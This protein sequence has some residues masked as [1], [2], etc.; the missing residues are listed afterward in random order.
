MRIILL[1]DVPGQGKCG[2]VLNVKEGYARNYLFPRNLAV[3]ASKGKI[4]ELD[5]RRQA[6][7]I[8]GR[9]KEYEARELAAAIKDVTVVVKAKTGEGGKLFGSVNN[10]DIADALVSQH[11]IRLDKKKIAVQEPIKRLGLYS[12]TAKLHPGVQAE[13]QVRV[14]GE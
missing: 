11:K 9:K 14:L 7:E 12:I 13:I 5:A 4:K 10:K 3:E 1:K 8:K 2:D 6:E